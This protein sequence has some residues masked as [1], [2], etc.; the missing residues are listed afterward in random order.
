MDEG[1]P[2]FDYKAKTL[3]GVDSNVTQAVFLQGD[4][5]NWEKPLLPL[6]LTCYNNGTVAVWN[7]NKV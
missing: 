1:R 2:K 3:R 5:L 6:L 4:T 7:V